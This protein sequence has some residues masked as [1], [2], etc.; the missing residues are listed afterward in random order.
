M[1]EYRGEAL[2]D[3]VMLGVLLPHNTRY[4]PRPLPHIP[5]L[6]YSNFIRPIP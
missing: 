1:M 5:L 4:P 6:V 3:E 2:V